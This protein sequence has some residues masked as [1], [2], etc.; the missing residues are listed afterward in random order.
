MQHRTHTCGQLTSKENNL[1]VVLNGWVNSIRLHGQIIFIDLRDRYG[2][3]QLVFDSK[4]FLG[5]L[6]NVKKLSLEDVLSIKGIVSLRAQSAVN[7]DIITG[8]IEILVSNVL[9]FNEAKPLPFVISDRNSAEENLRL[10]YRYLELRTEDLQRN[11]IIRHKTYQAVRSYLSN[12][13]FL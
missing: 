13:D 1:N 9:L 12:N 6:E 2:K 10:K 11:L 3:T 8:Q 5:D 4:T 7:K